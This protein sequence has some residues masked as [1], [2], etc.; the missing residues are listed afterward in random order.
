M[1]I[2]WNDL[3]IFLAVADAG[4]LSAVAKILR[5]TQPTVSRRIAELEESM[6]E[7]LFVRTVDGASPTS[8]FRPRFPA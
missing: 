5:V 7:Q 8:F 1:H 3:Q 6:G 4:S 2:P